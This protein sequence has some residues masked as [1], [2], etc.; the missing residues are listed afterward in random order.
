MSNNTFTVEVGDQAFTFTITVDDY[1]SFINKFS[2]KNKIA[3]AYNFCM[4]TV[5]KDDKPALKE[6][7][8]HPSVAPQ[9]ASA[10][11]EQYVPQLNIVVKPVR[12][13]A[14]N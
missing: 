6:L 3:P 4:Q 10:L 8:A 7:L 14:S 13:S 5:S 9:I 12:P 11:M 1:S 2:E